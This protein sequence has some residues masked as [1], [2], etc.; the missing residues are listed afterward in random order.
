V[1]KKAIFSFVVI[2]LI[3]GAWVLF[4][5]RTRPELFSGLSVLPDSTPLPVQDRPSIPPSHLNSDEVRKLSVLFEILRS[6]NDND[7]R[8]DSELREL[9]P[10]LKKAMEKKYY[11]VAVEKRNERGTIVFLVGR[12]ISDKADVDFL[13]GV[14]LEKACLG[15]HD[16]DKAENLNGVDETTANYPQLTALR[17]LTKEYERLTKLAGADVELKDSILRALQTGTQSANLKMSKLCDEAIRTL[18]Q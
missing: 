2:L 15:L 5:D 10:N 1:S 8:L 4:R 18:G 11:E 9:T 17:A 16:C 12:A 7:P 13:K 3:L 6:K 14:I